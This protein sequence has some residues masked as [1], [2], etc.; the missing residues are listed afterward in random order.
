MIKITSE[1]LLRY[2]YKE[3]SEQKAAIIRAALQTDWNLREAYE[4][5]VNAAKN[6]NEISLSPR[7]ETVNKILEY[8]SKRQVPVS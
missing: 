6:L 2:L 1:E 8:A 5:L 3:T 7:Q 4:K